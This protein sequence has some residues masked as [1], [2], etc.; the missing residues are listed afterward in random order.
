MRDPFPTNP[1]LLYLVL[2]VHTQLTTTV[3]LA[4]LFGTK[5]SKLF[6]F[7]VKDYQ[8]YA[9]PAQSQHVLALLFSAYLFEAEDFVCC[10]VVYS[11]S[12]FR[13]SIFFNI[14]THLCINLFS[15]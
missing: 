11:L 1:D 8:G 5:V 10:V 13:K 2:F 7:G 15:F 9:D 6:F 3:T 12:L 4:F 14:R